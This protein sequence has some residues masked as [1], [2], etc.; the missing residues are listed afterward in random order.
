MYDHGMK[1]P[2]PG[3]A[4]G[5]SRFSRVDELFT[6]RVSESIAFKT[7]LARHRR[8]VDD[9]VEIGVAR[10]NVLAFYGLGVLARPS[11]RKDWSIG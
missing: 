3:S 6:A 9:E 5:H 11:F 7:A 4:L 8:Y 1:V 10:H 2:P